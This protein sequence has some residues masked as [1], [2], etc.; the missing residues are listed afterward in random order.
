MYSYRE[1]W[2]MLRKRKVGAEVCCNRPFAPV[3]TAVV[4]TVAIVIFPLHRCVLPELAAF[5]PLPFFIP[6]RYSR[7]YLGYAHEIACRA[8]V[9][10]H[11]HA[12]MPCALFVR[13]ETCCPITSPCEFDSG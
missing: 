3:A 5:Y 7:P 4:S 1:A 9:L 11:L 10:G 12:G 8:F 2:G 6:S 13:R